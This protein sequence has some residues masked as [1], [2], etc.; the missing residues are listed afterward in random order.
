MPALDSLRQRLSGR[1][2][3][4]LAVNEE[5]DLDGARR[6]LEYFGFTFDVP[7]GRGR[8]QHAFGAPGLPFTALIDRRGR[9]AKTWIG[10]AGPEQITLMEALI[11]R[12]LAADR[13]D[14]HHHLTAAPGSTELVPRPPADGRP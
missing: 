14:H 3:T 5:H 8:M 11:L 9:I 10:Y 1:E 6:F 2:F 4:F 12:E 13:P 7:L